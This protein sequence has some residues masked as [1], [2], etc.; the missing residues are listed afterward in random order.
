MWATFLRDGGWG[1]HPVLGVLGAARA[2]LASRP[3][4][5]AA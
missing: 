1:T 4:Q 5:T 3:E 2:A